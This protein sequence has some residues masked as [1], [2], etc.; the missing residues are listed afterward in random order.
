MTISQYIFRIAYIEIDRFEVIS[1]HMIPNEVK[2][3]DL[4]TLFEFIQLL[5]V[6]TF[7]LQCKETNHIVISDPIRYPFHNNIN[8]IRFQLVIHLEIG[9][10]CSILL[11]SYSIQMKKRRRKKN[12][13][14]LFLFTRELMNY[15]Q[16]DMWEIVYIY[17]TYDMTKICI[18]SKVIIII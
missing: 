16:Y 4:K 13:F 8:W 14:F 17:I 11:I 6:D 9:V 7:V 1:F 18:H 15:D 5:T 10:Y 3:I 2:I 12:S